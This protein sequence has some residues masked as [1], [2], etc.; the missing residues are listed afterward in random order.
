MDFPP[1]YFKPHRPHN[2]RRSHT[3]N[4]KA[5]GYYLITISKGE[6]IPLFSHIER[7][8]GIL[9]ESNVLL[10]MHQ[11]GEII[12]EATLKFLERNPWFEFTDV[13]IMPDHIHIVWRVREWLPRKLQNYVGIYKSGCSL[14][15]NKSQNL[16]SG[17]GVKIFGE[18]FNDKIGYT[19]EIIAKFKVYVRDNPRRRYL[20][21]NHSDYFNR[22]IGVQI[23]GIDFHVFGNF[24]LLKHPRIA[25]VVISR[26]HTEEERRRLQSQ[27]EEIIRS[28]GVLISPFISKEEKEILHRAIEGEASI[29][30]LIPDGLYPR[31]KPQ[32]KEFDLCAEGRV[33]HIGEARPNKAKFKLSREYS[34]YLNQLAF[35]IAE[36]P[37]ECLYLLQR[38]K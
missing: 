4:Y 35:W 19:D 15:W 7:G 13:C 22:R 37:A 32:G 29:I 16:G 5:P 11:A 34:L 33:L 14:A 27:W 26:R 36:R 31:Y 10:K 17:S 6:D 2:C 21:L 3:H 12:R 8:E 20:V 24:H 25:P 23:D 38:G 9:G 1:D 18:N 28:G 30:R